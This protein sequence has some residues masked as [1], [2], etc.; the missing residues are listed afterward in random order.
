MS[1][2]KIRLEV[3]ACDRCKRE[4]ALLGGLCAPCFGQ[5]V[6]MGVQGLRKRLDAI[7]DRLSGIAEWVDVLRK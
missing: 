5:A 6:G 1:E 7:E 4:P 2:I 3:P